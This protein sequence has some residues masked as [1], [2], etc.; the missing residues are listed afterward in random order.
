MQRRNR[1]K[2][3]WFINNWRQRE[4]D[5]YDINKFPNSICIGSAMC[6]PTLADPSGRFGQLSES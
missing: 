1:D 5:S 3:S 2:S 4:V 6:C